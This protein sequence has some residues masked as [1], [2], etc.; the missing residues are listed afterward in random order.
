[1]IP[2]GGGVRAYRSFVVHCN[3]VAATGCSC[4]SASA[5]IHPLYN[6][7]EIK[8]GVRLA[9]LAPAARQNWVYFARCG[10]L[11]L[12][13]RLHDKSI[14]GD[15]FHHLPTAWAINNRVRAKPFRIIKNGYSCCNHK[16][17]KIKLRCK[18]DRSN[19]V[20][21]RAHIHMRR[22]QKERRKI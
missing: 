2:C 9:C 22:L 12:G 19:K 7:A 8:H 1:M 14:C 4:Q 18:N 5:N 6:F 15:E 21:R 20:S 10:Q 13:R 17:S 3:E 16:T 11:P